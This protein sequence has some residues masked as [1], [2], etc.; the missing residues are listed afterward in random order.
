[1]VSEV[2][3]ELAYSGDDAVG[4]LVFHVL[5]PLTSMQVVGRVLAEHRDGVVASGRDC[6]IGRR[7]HIGLDVGL[8]REAT[9][10]GIFIGILYPIG[11]WTDIERTGVLQP[12]SCT[13]EALETGQ[14]FQ[15]DIELN[16]SALGL[17]M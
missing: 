4:H 10:H 3:S 1:G 7:L 16:H 14:F 5:R 6:G 12:W 11:R 8:L 9:M 2:G 15:R 17:E 13:G